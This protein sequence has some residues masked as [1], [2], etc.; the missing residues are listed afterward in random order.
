MTLARVSRRSRDPP[1]PSRARIPRIFILVT[2]LL[3]IDFLI[4]LRLRLRL[5]P[6]ELHLLDRLGHDG[7]LPHL[8]L[9]FPPPPTNGTHL[10]P[11]IPLPGIH[12]IKRI[13]RLLAD[14]HALLA[15]L[16]DLRQFLAQTVLLGKLLA[17][18]EEQF[19][20]DVDVAKSD[21]FDPMLAVDEHDFGFTVQPV[22][23]VVGVVD[24]A[25]FVAVAC[26]VDDPVAIEVEEEGEEFAVVDDAAALC[27]RGGDDLWTLAPYST[28]LRLRGW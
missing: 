13:E 17:V 28:L 27:F 11:R 10:A 18:V 24:E 22:F 21:E 15:A 8:S 12:A 5:I 3:T 9:S 14:Q 2:V 25:R 4:R 23:L 7:R 1:A 20:A 19:F 26:G 6:I 16:F